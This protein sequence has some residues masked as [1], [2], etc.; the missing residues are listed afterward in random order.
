MI[1]HSPG[2][3]TVR[4]GTGKNTYDF[5]VDR[6]SEP[7]FQYFYPDYS[8]DV[9]PA[10]QMANFLLAVSDEEEGKIPS[11]PTSEGVE[12]CKYFFSLAITI[13]SHNGR[14][15]VNGSFCGLFQQSST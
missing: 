3:R 6:V 5:R 13:L 11:A 9:S 1:R 15:D 4:T 7:K 14:E 8:S 2:T 10:T 12:S